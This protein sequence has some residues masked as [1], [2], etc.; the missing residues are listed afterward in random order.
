MNKPGPNKGKTFY[1]CVRPVGPGYDKGRHERLRE[2]VD[3]QYKCNFFMWASYAMREV[4][5]AGG[6][7]G[8]AGVVRQGTL[9]CVEME[10][11]ELLQLLRSYNH[12]AA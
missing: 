2:E 10:R 12:T 7:D 3:H 11:S 1:L 9:E 6:S 4:M 5:S 8:A